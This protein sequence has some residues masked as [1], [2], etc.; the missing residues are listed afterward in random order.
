MVRVLLDHVAV[1]KTGDK[2][3]QPHY[4]HPK[5][6]EFDRHQSAQLAP[7]WGGEK[8][9]QAATD[10]LGRLVNPLLK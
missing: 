9:A 6:V 7:L 3:R 10:E 8:S 4:N 5:S 1:L 2:A